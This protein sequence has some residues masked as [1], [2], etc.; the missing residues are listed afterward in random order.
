MSWIGII[1]LGAA[2]IA[3][4]KAALERGD[5]DEAARQGAL[6]GPAVIEAALASP[7]RATRL[8][9]IVAA[10][11]TEDRA[12][13]LVPLAKLA[14]DPDRRVARPAAQAGRAIARE[15]AALEPTDDLAD[16][17][18]LAMRDDFAAVALDQTRWIDVRVA[19]I[20]TA[21]ALDQAIGRN[22]PRLLG[23][24]VTIALA[25]P[26]PAFRSAAITALPVPVPASVRTALVTVVT[27]D[28]SPRVAL[29][30]AAT[31]CADLA[32]D[33]PGPVLDALGADGIAK[34]R[35]LVKQKDIAPQL[36]RDANRCLRA[37][38]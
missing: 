9:G 32:T 5:L 11:A 27:S 30:A 36:V 17:D 1:V 22:L 3:S 16:A 34:V 20:E 7:D 21:A 19:A 10:P 38:R 4:M 33:A 25:D 12:E 15:L 37:A 13:L 28:A 18:V 29:T 31:L 8:A 35:T 24:P 2:G 14:A 26:D 6:A 23:V